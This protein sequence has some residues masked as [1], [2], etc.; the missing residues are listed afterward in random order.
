MKQLLIGIVI[1]VVVLAGGF[2]AAIMTLNSIDLSEY[3]EPIAD[4]VRDAIGRELHLN[5]A[6]NIN[7][8]LSPGISVNAVSVQNAGWASRDEMLLVEH[9]EAHLKLLPLVFGQIELSR[10][11]IVGLDLMLETDQHGKGNWEFEMAGDAA[12]DPEPVSDGD[13]F[14]TTAVLKKIVIR[15]AAIVYKDG[16]SGTVQRFRI[17]ELGAQMESAQAPL[18]IDLK[19][20]FGDEPV[21]LAGEIIGIAGLLSGGPLGLDLTV[22]ILDARARVTG[23]IQDAISQQGI[24][25]AVSLA[26]DSLAAWSGLAGTEIPDLGA[27]GIAADITGTAEEIQV[28]NLSLSGGGMQIDGDLKINI[29]GELMQLEASLNSPQ[30]DLTQL[31]PGDESVESSVDEASVTGEQ[32]S[33]PNERL[34]PDD[35]LPLEAMA[36]LDTITGSVKITFGELILDP[37][38]TLTNLNIELDVAPKTISVKPLNFKVMG[39]TVNGSG[40]LKLVGDKAEVVSMLDI[41]HPEAGSLFNDDDVTML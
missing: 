36:T 2:A 11:E 23:N 37:E 16:E 31:L 19:A 12:I 14:L 6:L 30:I 39:A 32:T 18:V 21:R 29:A 9:V 5:G 7:I 8:G 27:Y 20:S 41:H 40:K 26:G 1:L 34:F 33:D 38:T 25:V 4:V 24:D 35:P 10:L 22:D 28:T 15:D 3:E 17:A 13:T